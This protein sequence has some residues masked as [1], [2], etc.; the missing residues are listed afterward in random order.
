M[1]PY[2]DEQFLKE[3]PD[4]KA[5]LERARAKD[6]DTTP[7]DAPPAYTPRRHSDSGARRPS[8]STLRPQASN[9]PG[10]TTTAS[11]SGHR[12]FFGKMKDKAIGTKEERE[13]AKRQE[14]LVCIH[15]IIFQRPVRS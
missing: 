12:G 1:H 11:S 10:P 3:H 2:E 13:E 6:S 5:R 7:L 4:V 9:R 8:S 15:C 14:A